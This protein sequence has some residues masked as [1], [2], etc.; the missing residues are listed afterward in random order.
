MSPVNLNLTLPGYRIVRVESNSLM[1]VYA[2]LQE[3]LGT[4]VYRGGG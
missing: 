4:G 3:S 2:G 1:R